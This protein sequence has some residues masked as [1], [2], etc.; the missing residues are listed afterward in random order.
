[1]QG[2]VDRTFC[3]A[4][5]SYPLGRGSWGKINFFLGEEKMRHKI[6]RFFA[7]LM[8][9]FMVLLN[10]PV[11]TLAADTE[12]HEIN[13]EIIHTPVEEAKAGQR[14]ALE[15][16]VNDEAG[17]EIVRAYFK[18]IEAAEFNFVVLTSTGDGTYTGT[19]P[20]PANGV[21]NIDYLILVKNARN[22]VVKTQTYRIT[23]EDDDDAAQAIANNKQINVYT[24][25]QQAPTEITGFSDNIVIDVVESS[26]KLGAVVGIYS[27][28]STGGSTSG[29]VAGGTVAASTAGI[30]TTAIVVGSIAA[31]AAAGGI[32]AVASSSSSDD[33]NHGGEALSPQ[34]ILGLWSLNGTHSAGATTTGSM[35][36][37]DNSTFSA[38]FDNYPD[39]NGTWSLSGT[40]LILSFYG[41]DADDAG[42]VYNGTVSGNSQQFTMVSDNGWTLNFSR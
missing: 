31:V 2:A 1:M 3:D 15:A 5:I 9:P 11:I 7:M 38:H 34:T 33:D 30:S 42:A 28:I 12:L 25:L 18:A 23:V 36:F 41:G 35:T 20:A 10:C 6:Y 4:I 40:N 26:A 32:A 14:I 37:N 8:M 21:G 19:L 22:I 27:N 13:I 29:A 39:G 16:E 24:E 17:V